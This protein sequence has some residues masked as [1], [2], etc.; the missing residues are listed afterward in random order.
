MD[1]AI[2][3]AQSVRTGYEAVWRELHDQPELVPGDR[4]AIRA[5]LRRLN[6]LGFSVDLEVDPVGPHGA[7]RLRT[8]VTTRRYHAS[9]LE[10]RTRI[11]ALEGQARILLHDLG[12]YQA[13]LEFY[14]R[15]SVETTEAAERWLTE[16]YRPTLAR[17]SGHRR[18]RPGPRPGVLRRARA[19]VAAVRAGAAATWASRPR[20][21]RTSPRGRPRRSG[22]D[23]RRPDG[24]STGR[25]RRSTRST[26]SPPSEPVEDGALSPPSARGGRRRRAAPAAGAWRRGQHGRIGRVAEREDVLAVHAGREAEQLRACRARRPSPGSCRCRAPTRRASS[27]PPR[28]P[29]PTATLIGAS[30]PCGSG[31]TRATAAAAP[32]MWPA[33]GPTVESARRRSRSSTTMN[34]QRCWFLEL[35]ARRPASRICSRC[36]GSSGRPSKA[37]PRAWCGSRRRRSRRPVRRHRGPSAPGRRWRSRPRAVRGPAWP[38]RA[39]GATRASDRK[40]P[41]SSSSVG[42]R[43]PGRGGAR[44]G[45]PPATAAASSGEN[46]PPRCSVRNRATA[47][48]VLREL[49]QPRVPAALDEQ[50]LG[51]GA[52]GERAR[53]AAAS[54]ARSVDRHDAVLGAVDEQDRP[55][56]GAHGARRAH[57]ANRVAAG[58]E[59][60]AGR[61]PGE[62]PGDRR[63]DRQP[64]EP[65]RLAGQPVRVGGRRRPRS[66]RRRRRPP[67]PRPAR[68]AA[69]IE[70]PSSPI[71]VTSGRR[72][73]LARRRP[74][75]RPRTRRPTSAAPRAR[76]RRS[77][78]RR[79]SARGSRPRAGP[80]RGGSSGRGPTPSRG[81]A[82]RPVARPVRPGMYQ[83]GSRRPSGGRDLDVLV[84]EADDVRRPGGR[85]A[86]RVAGPD[87]VDE[88]EPVGERDRQRGERGGEARPAGA[89]GSTG[90]GHAHIGQRA[91]GRL[92]SDGAP[93]GG[94]VHSRGAREGSPCRAGRRARRQPRRH[95]G[96]LARPRP[97]APPRPHR[98]RPRGRAAR[99]APDGRDQRGLRGADPGRRD[100]RG[101]PPRRER[102]RRTARRPAAR[103]A[104]RARP[105][106]RSAAGEAHPPDHRAPRPRAAP[107]GR[108]TRRRPRRGP[109][110]R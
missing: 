59:V 109:A 64:G 57:G 45:P 8:S 11:R 84:G 14:E 48:A 42:E 10:R 100:H 49:V 87:A 3:A 105:A 68:P 12:E 6:D 40:P 50:R 52:P 44:R 91:P 61:Q 36:A 37:G 110:C 65:E 47:V 32:A 5:R 67:R 27:G 30:G 93:T 16:V 75:R 38:P 104:D 7:V 76:S 88:R 58:P 18:P 103:A 63:R 71:R 72:A 19:Q 34:A 94:S 31:V 89:T 15:R 26:W 102:R 106:R 98:R 24:R 39:G 21:S 51:H 70:W 85:M 25:T 17:I 53:R 20:S 66:R 43:A 13:W 28:R 41:G 97:P 95:Q 83:P 99:D 56:D 35:C 54:R 101:A 92:S 33:Y 80:A 4:Q 73:Q 69:P 9:E 82:R 29:G 78:G 90:D 2:E 81:P 96:R 79:T 23:R 55:V 86:V 60:D 1:E 46:G 74:G 77:R 22:R 108:A 107:S 62:R